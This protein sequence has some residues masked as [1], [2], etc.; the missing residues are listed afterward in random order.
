MSIRTILVPFAENCDT[1]AVKTALATARHLQAHLVGVYVE[2]K[3]QGVPVPP[4]R[5]SADPRAGAFGMST[6]RGELATVDPLAEVTRQRDQAAQSTKAGFEMMCR[7]WQVPL[8]DGDATGQANR[9]LPSASF[10]R[11]IG[12]LPHVIDQHG[13]TCDMIVTESASVSKETKAARSAIEHAL[14]NS[15]RP[16]LLAPSN[17]PEELNGR[18]LVA[19]SDRP[20]CWHA[21]GAALPFLAKAKDVLLFHVGN[22][23]AERLAE[24]K[25]ADYLAWHGIEA[26]VLQDQPGPSGVAE[27]L[28]SQCGERRVDLM[29]MGA[30]SRSPL[31]ERLLGGVTYKVLSNV[32]ATPVL[33][34]H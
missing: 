18:I 25:A 20:P 24:E 21:L 26:E 5:V 29:V 8:L 23:R 19:W 16:V 28:M 11:Q 15:G 4:P 17:P 12:D 10:R 9:P 1:P 2:A 7:E 33:M 13:H 3:R 22:E 27:Y 30:Y 6:R 31:R 34:V 14:L 32:A